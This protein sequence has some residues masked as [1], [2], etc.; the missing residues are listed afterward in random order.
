MGEALSQVILNALPALTRR[1]KLKEEEGEVL[2][3]SRAVYGLVLKLG[4]FSHLRGKH[5]WPPIDQGPSPKLQA[6]L[7][8]LAQLT[9]VAVLEPSPWDE[10]L[11]QHAWDLLPFPAM[12]EA[13]VEA[14]RKD[15]REDV[16]ARLYADLLP[17]AVRRRRGE[18][19]TPSPIAAFL[20]RWAVRAP[21]DTVLDPGVGSG[22]LLAHAFE[23][24]VELG[25]TPSAAIGQ[26]AG[27]DLNPLALL[28]TA[29]TLLVRDDDAPLRLTCGDFLKAR[30]PSAGLFT[31]PDALILPLVD[32][33]VCN[34]P[35]SRHHELD[36]AEKEAIARDIERETGV[37]LSRLSGLYV[38]FLIHATRFLK[39][40]GRMAVITSA[41]WLDVGYGEALKQFLR[42]RLRIHAL[43]RFDARLLPFPEILT[44][45]SILLL[46]QTSAAP[47][48]P[49]KLVSLQ[50]WPEADELLHIID[51]PHALGMFP[52]GAVQAILQGTLSPEAKW[53]RSGEP[54]CQPRP[55]PAPVWTP[56]GSLATVTRGIA[57]GANAFFTLTEEEVR[58]WGLERRFLRPVL[59]RAKL[60]S[61]YDFTP[62]DFQTL[63]AVGEKVWL[64]YC[65]KPLEELK[66]T[67]LLRYLQEGERQGYR[68]RYLCTHRPVW[69]WLD[70][71]DPAPIVVTYMT[72]QPPRFIHNLAEALILNVFH[73]V[74]PVPEIGTE[75]ILLKALLAYLNSPLALEA[76]H[77]VGR[78]YGGGLYKVEPRELERLP[79]VD[80][81]RLPAP[82]LQ[83]LAMLFKALCTAQRQRGSMRQIQDELTRLLR[84]LPEGPCC[85]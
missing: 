66:G 68:E 2:E 18:F 26:L 65:F 63:R 67:R 34:P 10:R 58:R 85:S 62:D 16:L 57:T 21:T 1:L 15:W 37:R 74:T 83:E 42:D 7:A 28:M 70:R 11:L 61:H 50:A 32:A 75:P 14:V 55:H 48:E 60:A 27:I 33:V 12:A 82:M 24:L 35:Y 79:V 49:V 78:F 25:A 30:P 77:Q 9:N 31:E 56:L 44:T 6:A 5:R 43:L 3:L 64:L 36:P 73:G 38:Y 59:T 54:G 76:M 71:R 51:D 20:T 40:Q 13:L 46:E 23:R 22:I 29:F 53:G 47:E 72:R 69:Y 39:E 52:W 8:R 45:A 4:I 41:E 84:N 19:P 81:R 80:P 17:Q